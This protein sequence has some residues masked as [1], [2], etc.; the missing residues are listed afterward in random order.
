MSTQET[1]KC[2]QH[3][4]EEAS[5]TCGECGKAICTL[6]MTLT[7]EGVRCKE[8]MAR[9]NARYYGGENKYAGSGWVREPEQ[10]V[11]A[12]E[13]SPGQETNPK[14]EK[15]EPQLIE[16]NPVTGEASTDITY[17]RRHPKIETGLRCARCDT[18]ICPR[19]MVYSSVGL[20]CPDCEQSPRPS[21]GVNPNISPR[22]S[23]NPKNGRVEER[24]TGFRTYWRRTTPRYIIEPRHYVQA[25]LAAIG[26][27][28]VGG[29]AWGSLL[30]VELAVRNPVS[31]FVNSIHL[32]P[33][34]LLGVLLGEAV[35]RAT[36]DRRGQG[37]QLI[38]V[39][40]VVLAY[41]VAIATL[42]V[43]VVTR[44]GGD[45]PE[46]NSLINATW[47][48]FINL[49]SGGGSSGG[50]TILLFFVIGGVFAWIRLKR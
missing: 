28:L 6:C 36:Q 30:N 32:V 31:G 21:I 50:L 27:A 47:T 33:E 10:I 42:L 26:A 15:S 18:P 13:P 19:C 24:D 43:R 17:C 39:G 49:F 5:L 38:A 46:L 9:L 44:R 40:G 8:C 11:M 1:L 48:V 34:I 35:A 45:F 41:L 12:A 23:V 25:V 14:A 4:Q 22:T 29:V 2:Q 3:P 16:I 7:G 20:R 37:L